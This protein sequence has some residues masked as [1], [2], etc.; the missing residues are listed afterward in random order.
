MFDEFVALQR[1][2]QADVTARVL[3]LTGAGRAFSAGL[4]LDQAAQLPDVPAAQMLAGQGSWARSIAGIGHM[5]KPVIAAVNGAA[6]GEG[7]ALALAADIRVAATTARFNAAF[8]RIG[9]RW[10]WRAATRCSPPAPPTWSRRWP[11][12]ARSATLTS[13][14]TDTSQERKPR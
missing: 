6:A 4:D 11:P 2:V 14:A 9:R 8:V 1:D 5:T 13:S 12:S 3:V 7:M 10:P